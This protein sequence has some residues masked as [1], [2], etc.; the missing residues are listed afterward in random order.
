[1]MSEP[2]PPVRGDEKQNAAGT[3]AAAGRPDVR[4]VV[5]GVFLAVALVAVMA[6]ALA[7]DSRLVA[8]DS[9]VHT[10]V[11]DQRTGGLT[12]VAIAVAV[13]SEYVAYVAAAVGAALA[14]RPRPW[15]FGAG[16]G[17]LLLAFGQ[18]VRVGLAAAA[19]RSRPPEADWEMYAAG[20]ALP[21]GHTTTATFAAGLLC[22]GLARCLSRAGLVVAVIVLAL[23]AVAGGVGRVYLGVHWPTDI[24]AGWLLGGLLTVLAAG[25]LVRVRASHLQRAQLS[26]PDPSGRSES[27][28]P[29]K[30]RRGGEV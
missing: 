5:L 4:L 10:A 7:A 2:R 16:A 6:W 12:A 22:L 18:G 3:V 9:T 8:W 29:V 27:G 13:T 23:W 1:M 20:F 17:I 24:I 28:H 26:P 11:M 30:Q 21:S 14:L 19:G 25:L 15:W